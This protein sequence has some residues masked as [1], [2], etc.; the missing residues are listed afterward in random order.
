MFN[1]LKTTLEVI[2]FISEKREIRHAEIRIQVDEQQKTNARNTGRLKFRN[3][4]LTKVLIWKVERN[5]ETE[6]RKVKSK[7]C[8]RQAHMSIML[9][10]LPPP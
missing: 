3:R 6:Q 7:V 4:W 2:S 5:D 9:L 1:T 8:N 10:L